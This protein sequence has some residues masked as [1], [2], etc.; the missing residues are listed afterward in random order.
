MLYLS[1][2]TYAVSENTLFSTKNPLI[3]SH[4]FLGKISAIFGK[5]ST[6]TLSNSVKAVFDIFW[7]CFQF[8]YHNRLLLMKM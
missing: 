1:T 5:N 3:L 6:L 7:F 2:H 4:H 8:L